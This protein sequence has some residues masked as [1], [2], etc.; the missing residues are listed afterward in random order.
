MLGGFF[1]ESRAGDCA[2]FTFDTRSKRS[3]RAASQSLSLSVAFLPPT[4][5][6]VAE[7]PPSAPVTVAAESPGENAGTVEGQPPAVATT[8][9]GLSPGNVD[10]ATEQPSAPAISTE[11]PP[12]PA[13]AV[14][15]P[16]SADGAG[17]GASPGDSHVTT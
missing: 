15:E 2:N 4:S 17:N 12:E 14:A 8:T 1:D 10:A 16:P 3:L 6:T 13:I 9:E 5:T 11:V 7:V